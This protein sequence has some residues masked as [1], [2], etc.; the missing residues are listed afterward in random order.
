M[1]ERGMTPSESGLGEAGSHQASSSKMTIGIV[2]CG[3]G[4]ALFMLIAFASGQV[5]IGTGV[6]GAF[7]ALGVAFI[8][9]AM[10]ARRDVRTSAPLP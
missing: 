4:A 8:A 6:G 2:L 10:S 3:L 5:G 7:V 9:S 1:I